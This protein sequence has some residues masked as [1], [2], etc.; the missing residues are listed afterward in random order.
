MSMISDW[1]KHPRF[2]HCRCGACVASLGPISRRL[3]LGKQWLA[4]YGE[5]NVDFRKRYL[6]WHKENGK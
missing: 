1:R 6:D 2:F 3:G 5:S 4:K